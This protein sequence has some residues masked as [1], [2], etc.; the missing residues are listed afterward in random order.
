MVFSRFFYK[1]FHCS[2]SDKLENK[3]LEK[4]AH[5]SEMGFANIYLKMCG[6]E[7]R[8]YYPLLCL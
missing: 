8:V 4:I 1:V 3:L 6:T 7:I 2:V 5:F